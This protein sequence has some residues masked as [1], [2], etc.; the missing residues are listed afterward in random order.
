MS[1]KDK[2]TSV[3]QGRACPAGASAR[4]SPWPRRSAQGW[5]IQGAHSSQLSD[6]RCLGDVSP[7]DTALCVVRDRDRELASLVLQL[8]WGQGEKPCPYPGSPV[9]WAQATCSRAMVRLSTQG[10]QEP[11][12][13]L[14]QADL[15]KCTLA[16]WCLLFLLSMC[17][18][19]C[20]CAHIH[21]PHALIQAYIQALMSMCTHTHVCTEF[22]RFV[23]CAHLCRVHLHPLAL[24][25]CPSA[26]PKS[27]AH[28]HTHLHTHLRSHDV[29]S[30]RNQ[31]LFWEV[32]AGWRLPLLIPPWKCPGV[33]TTR[34]I[35]PGAAQSQP[36][37]GAG[38]PRATS[39]HSVPLTGG[40]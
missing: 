30:I 14:A 32:L 13:A 20:M 2:P 40:Q 28:P 10:G 12:P 27:H 11:G 35:P 23:C 7:E 5:T 9:K 24:T 37:S 1:A 19:A 18:C 22:T 26:T 15:R 38:R 34:Y 17:M 6:R 4:H 25:W 33:M 21:V 36:P 39:S 16:H 3:P 31:G 29:I 8:S